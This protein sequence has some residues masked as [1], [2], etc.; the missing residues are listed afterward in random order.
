[1]NNETE[2]IE[3][4]DDLNLKRK[5]HNKQ[6]WLVLLCATIVLYS[7]A[8]RHE[9]SYYTPPRVSHPDIEYVSSS[10]L[11]ALPVSKTE[12]KATCTIKDM[13]ENLF[14]DTAAHVNVTTGKYIV[15]YQNDGV[16]LLLFKE[17]IEKSAKTQ[18]GETI[19]ARQFSYTSAEQDFIENHP[20]DMITVYMNDSEKA[21][22][23]N[24]KCVIDKSSQRITHAE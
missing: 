2:H 22:I 18:K 14:T 21:D 17:D 10:E 23:Q 13:P 20:D 9:R 8:T 12:Y 11:E 6:G 3:D 5:K 15:E 24:V 7:F 4:L 16:S 1:M 19:W